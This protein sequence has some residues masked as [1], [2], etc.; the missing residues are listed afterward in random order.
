MDLGNQ[1][2][3]WPL[4][5][6]LVSLAA[7][8]MFLLVNDVGLC[9]TLSLFGIFTNLANIIV[10][11]KMGF[12]E[13]SNMNFLA[14][15]VFDLLV[16]VTALFSKLIYSSLLRGVDMGDTLSLVSGVI[17]FTMFVVIGG[18]AMVT[19]LISTE[20]CLC[21]VFPL[22]MKR[23]ITQSRVLCLLLLIVIYHAV[24][25][26]LLFVGIRIPDNELILQLG[27]HYFSLMSSRYKKV[28]CY[29]FSLRKKSGKEKPNRQAV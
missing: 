25:I 18:S 16:S 26:I 27:V 17:S 8:D 22:Q 6:P 21:I 4:V 28:F 24:F 12:S 3:V 9:S 23:I 19:A 20:R 5:E 7:L 29:L 1:T 2:I 15:S 11:I 13:T 14:L 10:F